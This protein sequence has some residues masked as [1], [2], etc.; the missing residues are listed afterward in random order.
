MTQQLVQQ[1]FLFLCFFVFFPLETRE[2]FFLS[3]RHNK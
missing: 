1:Y 2:S 3:R